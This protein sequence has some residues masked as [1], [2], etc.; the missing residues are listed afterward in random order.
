MVCK[1]ISEHLTV[2]FLEFI[3]IYSIMCELFLVCSWF[4]ISLLRV[5]KM[6]AVL[7]EHKRAVDHRDLLL[8]ESAEHDC[9]K[10]QFRTT[11]NQ[12]C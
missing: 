8:L 2:F 9:F 6:Q 5:L 12:V 4:V 10:F 7:I 1:L 3:I 11:L